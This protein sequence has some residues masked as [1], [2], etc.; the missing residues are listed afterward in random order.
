MEEKENE[1]AQEEEEEDEVKVQVN[2][3]SASMSSRIDYCHHCI[4]VLM[5]KFCC[6]SG[7]WDIIISDKEHSLSSRMRAKWRK[8]RMRRLKRKRR[9]MRSRSK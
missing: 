4:V 1:E 7:A 8:K 6:C 2:R 5:F 3:T 9:K